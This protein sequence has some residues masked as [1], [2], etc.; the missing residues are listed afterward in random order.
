MSIV[1]THIPNQN[2]TLD[3]KNVKYPQT[4]DPNSP[5]NYF[6]AAFAGARGSGKTWLSC[7]LIKSLY[8]KKVYDG[9]KMVPQRVIL[10]SPSAHS[11]SNNIFKM[12]N[13][14]WDD[15]V[16][17]DYTD[18]GLDSIVEELTKDQQDAK[19]YRDYVKAYIKF[20]AIN[21]IDDLPIEQ[22]MLLY[23]KDFIDP[24]FLPKP[25]FP[26][27]FY[28]VIIL[29][30]VLGTSALRQGRSRLTYYMLKNRHTAG[31]INFLINTQNLMAIPKSIRINLNFLAVFR[32][33]NKE[34]VLNDLAPLISATTTIEE[35]DAL[36]SYATKDDMHDALIIDLTKSKPIF[37]RNLDTLLELK[38]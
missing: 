17:E 5:Q 20:E 1:E 9:E 11:P 13:I 37:K 6:C 28:T 4:K 35:F 22:L 24:D 33:A 8:D 21:K 2:V 32:F 36:Y 12:L 38:K 30:D 15:D 14:D 34:V 18:A 31:G 10:I 19:E 29:D 23:S 16:Y 3:V 27:G 25:K 26:D 7:K